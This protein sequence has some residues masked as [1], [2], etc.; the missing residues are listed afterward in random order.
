MALTAKN[1]RTT[2]QISNK[3]SGERAKATISS[4]SALKQKQHDSSSC[5]Q[6]YTTLPSA[7]TI[8][9]CGV[10]HATLFPF[11]ISA[12]KSAYVKPLSAL[13]SSSVDTS[14]FRYCKTSRWPLTASAW[15]SNISRIKVHGEN[16]R[17]M[18]RAKQCAGAASCCDL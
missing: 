7:R 8:A 11:S 18:V 3:C 9:A 4:P 16:R 1:R 5:T 2:S 12:Y 15:L 17:S 14:R 13:R 10:S 6:E